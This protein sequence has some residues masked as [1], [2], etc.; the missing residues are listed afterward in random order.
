LCVAEALACGVPVVVSR[1]VNLAADVLAAG[2]GWVTGLGPSELESALA[3]AMSDAA[4]RERRGQAG[5][6]FVAERFGFPQVT[7]ELV[8]L[9]NCVISERAARCDVTHNPS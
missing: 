3:A 2:A 1:Q 4:E 7:R 5:R 6:K 8:T 9:Y